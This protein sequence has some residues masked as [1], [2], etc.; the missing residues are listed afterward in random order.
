MVIG[1]DGAGVAARGQGSRAEVVMVGP[2]IHPYEHDDYV[3]IRIFNLA[4]R[5]VDF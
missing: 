4:I 1:L 2:S 3:Y 5:W